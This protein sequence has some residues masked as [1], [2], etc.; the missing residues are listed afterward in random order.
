MFR[1]ARD[2]TCELFAEQIGSTK[3][4]HSM[5]ERTNKQQDKVQL[6]KKLLFS[7]SELSPT[8]KSRIPH[9]P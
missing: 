1:S 6:K 3:E 2:K 5:K 9:L 4:C 7:S 8:I